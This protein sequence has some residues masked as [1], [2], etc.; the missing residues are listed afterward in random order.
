MTSDLDHILLLVP[1]DP[2]LLTGGKG[3]SRPA[4][5][6]HPAAAGHAPCGRCEGSGLIAVGEYEVDTCPRC[7][8]GHNTGKPE[9]HTRACTERFSARMGP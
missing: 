1:R 3:G 9:R 8:E 5:V 7:A 2:T 6:R 4:T